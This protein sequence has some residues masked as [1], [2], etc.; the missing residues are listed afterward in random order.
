MVK[1]HY[2]R[3]GNEMEIEALTKVMLRI[4]AAFIIMSIIDTFS[5]FSVD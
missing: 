2:R 3:Y 4:K 1:S 5:I